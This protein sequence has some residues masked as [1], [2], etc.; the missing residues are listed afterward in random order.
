MTS[1][2]DFLRN[3]LATDGFAT[4]DVLASLLPLMRETLDAHSVGKVA[5]L[6]GLDHLH[7]EDGRIW[8]EQA[9]RLPMRDNGAAIRRIAVKQTLAVEVIAEARRTVDIDDGSDRLEDA[10]VGDRDQE[11]RTPVYLPGYVA[12]EHA[13]EHHDPLTDVFS[14]GMIL[15]SMACGLDFA[16][17]EQLARFVGCRKN[18]FALN[19]DLHP[20]LAQAIVR[21]TELDRHRRAQDLAALIRN[22]ENYREQEVDFDFELARLAELQPPGAPT[23]QHA[24]LIKLRERLFEISRRNRLLNFRPTMQTVN[25][26]HASVPLSFDHKSIQPEQILVWNDGLQQALIRSG[27]LSLNRYLNFNE[28]LYLPGVLDSLA[29]EARRDQAEFGFAQLRLVLCFVHWVNLKES[30]PERFESPL[31][32]LPVELKK[33]KG[34]RD[35]YTLDVLETEAEINPVIRHQFRELYGI[36]LPETIDLAS[37][38]LDSLYELLSAQIQASEPAVTLERIDRPRIALIHEKARRRM[39]LYRHRARLAGRGVRTFLDLDYSYDAANYHPLGL[40]LFHAKIRSP[41]T[42]LREIIEEKPRPRSFVSP[43]DPPAPVEVERTFYALQGGGAENPYQWSFDL[44]SVTLANFKYRKMSLVRD[45]EALLDQQPSSEAFDA[46]FSLVPRPAGRELPAAPPLEDRYDVVPCDPTQAA[47]I[48]EAREGRSYII[49]GPPGTGKSQTITNLIAD[50]AARG[51]RVLFVC[52]KRAAIDVV[53]AR[54]RQCG[55]AESCC[56]IHDSQTDKRGFVMDLKQTYETALADAVASP[57]KKRRTRTR[58]TVLTQ[59]QEEL[60]PLVEFDAAMEEIPE[61]SAVSVRQ[62]V[63]RC[64]ELRGVLPELSPLDREQLPSYA[65]WWPHRDRLAAL[66]AEVREFQPEGILARHPLAMLSPRVTQ[67]DRPLRSITQAVQAAE[68]LISELVETLGKSEIDR[69]NWETLATARQ[70]V[71]YAAGALPLAEAGQM[72]LLDKKSERVKSF[73]RELQKLRGRQSAFEQ[74]SQATGA[75]IEKLPPDTLQTAWL[76]AQRFER[77]WFAFLK[78]SWWRLRALLNRSYNFQAHALRPTWTQILAALD[79]EYRAAAEC[80]YQEDRLANAFHITGNVEEFVQRLTEVRKLLTK[81]PPWLAEIHRDMLRSKN[82][83]RTLRRIEQARQPLQRLDET[84]HPIADDYADLPW[85]QLQQRLQDVA[86]A[87]DDL[88]DYLRSMEQMAGLPAELQSTLRRTPLTHSALEAAVADT[89]LQETYRQNRNL[90]RFNGAA[91]LRHVE[92]IESLYDDWL[93]A[94]ADEIRRRLRERFLDHVRLANLPASQLD[95]EQKETR[96]RYNRGRREVEHEFGKSMRYKAIRE[97]VSGDSGEV[98]KDLKPVWLMS[99]LSVSDTLPMDTQHFDVVIFDEASQVTLEEAVPSIFRAAQAIVVGDEM[100][101]PPTDF[102]SAKR[103]G[104]DDDMLIDEQ[105]ELVRYDLTSN[106][107]LNHAAKNLP[108]TMLGWHYRSRS[109]SLISFSNWTFYDGRLL[110]VPDQRLLPAGCGPIEAARAEDGQAGAAALRQRPVS[111]HFMQHGVYE[112]RRNRAEAD[113][114]AHLVRELLA[115]GSGASIGIVAFS[116]AQQNE[117]ETALTRLAQDDREFADRLDAETEREVDGQF[118]GLLVKNLENIQGDER[119]IVILSVCYGPGPDGRML[120]N[121]GP[122]NQSGGEKRLNVAFS[123]AKH[124]MAV[125][126]SIRSDRITNEY[127]DGANCLKNYLRYSQAV[128][129]GDGAAA[130]RVLRGVTRW[131]EPDQAAV[132]ADPVTD[133]IAAALAERGLIVDRSIGQSY[134]RCDLAVRLEG[135]TAYRLGILVD[136]GAY[137]EQEDILERDMMRPRLLR[138]FGWPLAFVLSKDWFE[139]RSAVLDRLLAQSGVGA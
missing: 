91:R 9:K 54:L 6:E 44:C 123:R 82:A 61:R 12:W 65:A 18:L 45:Y 21:M 95:A 77:D 69:A 40:T 76:Q 116:E 43:A 55:L 131:H 27:S 24:V 31:V 126:S 124:H 30:P 137:Y 29:A 73:S 119:D 11:I 60:A 106:S 46:T 101:L 62:L 68:A 53:Y 36:Q 81:C 34:I 15:A 23:K 25:L 120:M 92:R 96:K 32:L 121:F 125:V 33:K 79:A 111:F 134:F 127:N 1:F 14:L 56:L 94:N 118:V 84:L 37:A 87:L 72:P 102:F 128:S 107:F 67:I 78:P 114:I 115:Q 39:D 138:T 47:A 10:A 51:K 89:A 70:L 8:F 117:I 59:L 100:Q 22:L 5:P 103:S 63:E 99:P 90:Q 20:V 113:Y 112:K 35:L 49:Q 4:A 109:E 83:A 139:D 108:S 75:W 16:D 38:T 97:L 74:A 110:T 98:I 48:V 64:V 3:R 88:P 66:D 7:V 57:R 105:G 71:D 136:S 80:D 58:T 26:T 28:A 19:R 86:A 85:D 104:D 17:R 2:H 132:V 133:Q 130:Q 93:N 42:H 50:F 135:E 129:E 122:I 13:L 41:A 52:E